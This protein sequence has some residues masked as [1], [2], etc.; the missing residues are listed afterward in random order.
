MSAQSRIPILAVKNLSYT[1]KSIYM[2]YMTGT[3]FKMLG[4][5]LFKGRGLFGRSLRFALRITSGP[6]Q[7]P[8]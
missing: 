2:L 7:L 6:Y 1:D 8:P 5:F 4:A 3:V